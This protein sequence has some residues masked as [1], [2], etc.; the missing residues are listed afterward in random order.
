MENKNNKQKRNE[1][2][3][4]SKCK[5]CLTKD[6]FKIKTSCGHKI[7]LECLT[8][9]SKTLC[10]FCRKDLAGEIPE[11]I[12]KIIKNNNTENNNINVNDTPFLHT[13]SFSL[14]IDNNGVHVNDLNENNDSIENMLG[15][16]FDFL[17]RLF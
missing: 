6:F 4:L 12:I 3:K 16:G 5:I 8:K 13:S 10:P 15:V 17:N 9:L 2:K 11:N 14:R 7:C 1:N